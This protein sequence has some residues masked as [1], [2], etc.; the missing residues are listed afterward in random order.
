MQGSIR[1]RQP[2]TPRPQSKWRQYHKEAAI[3]NLAGQRRKPQTHVTSSQI[4]D[5]VKIPEAVRSRTGPAILVSRAGA[6]PLASHTSQRGNERRTSRSQ[7]GRPF[8][9]SHS[10]WAVRTRAPSLENVALLP[11]TRVPFSNSRDN[12]RPRPHRIHTKLDSAVC[13]R[14]QAS[15]R[16]GRP[17]PSASIR[18]C[19]TYPTPRETALPPALP[20]WPPLILV[21]VAL[22]ARQFHR[23]R[24]RSSEASAASTPRP[25]GSHRAWNPSGLFHTH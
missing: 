19:S 1:T 18:R 12:S 15:S 17:G 23:T 21:T 25:D 3:S 6:I 5:P 22:G 10:P 8:P 14:P 11:L 24:N 20:D 7:N 2:R 9:V 4:P 16:K 13:A